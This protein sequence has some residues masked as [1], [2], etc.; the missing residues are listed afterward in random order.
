MVLLG[1]FMTAVNSPWWLS[2]YTDHHWLQSQV[3]RLL[4]SLLSWS[5]YSLDLL[6]DLWKLKYWSTLTPRGRGDV[7]REEVV[8]VWIRFVSVYHFLVDEMNRNL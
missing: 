6:G 7:A 5:G 1:L 8:V 3:C 4:D 2:D